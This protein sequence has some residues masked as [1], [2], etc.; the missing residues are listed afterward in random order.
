M[1]NFIRLVIII[2]AVTF[3]FTIN[4]SSI[5]VLAEEDG[6]IKVVQID[7]EVDQE[8]GEETDRQED[9]ELEEDE[10]KYRGGNKELK[11]DEEQDRE[12]DEELEEEEGRG[13]NKKD[14]LKE[15][16]KKLKEEARKLWEES[17]DRLEAEKDL[18][19]NK[20]DEVEAQKDELE[21]QLQLAEETGD[22]E[23]IELLKQQISQYKEQMKTLK[24]DMGQIKIQMKEEIRK[25]YTLEEL[26]NINKVSEELKSKYKD[27]KVLGVDSVISEGKSFKFDTPPVIKEG[28]TLIPVR[29]I[30]EGFGAEVS[31]DDETQ[32]VTITK[33]DKIIK[34]TI[35]SVVAVVDGEEIQIDAKSEIMNG[36]TVVPL[37]FIIE[38]LGLKIEWDSET[39]TIEIE[40]EIEDDN[41]SETEIEEELE[42]VDEKESEN[43]EEIEDDNGV[44]TELEEDIENATENGE[45]I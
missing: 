13:K 22:T 30:T 29:A 3:V 21:K 42:D 39:E 36:R 10:E 26:N 12:E 24:N 1:R 7:E 8:E 23:L 40:E 43:E 18:I 14:T 17:K 28:R 16:A 31:W 32:E 35:G 25:R 33:D 37:R 11:E 15:E 6:L 5:Q 4:F 19:E 2:V 9:E 34:L 38:S 27:V 45:E 41:E 20:K 44:E